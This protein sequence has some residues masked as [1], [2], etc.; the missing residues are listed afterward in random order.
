MKC[1]NLVNPNAIDNTN[2]H[3]SWKII[4]D[5]P[6]RQEA[7]EIQVASDSMLL[8]NGLPDLWNL[9][10]IDASTSVMVP[11]NG[12]A[13]SSR[14]LCWWRVRVWNGQGE[15]SAWSPV[16]RFGIGILDKADMKGSF[17]GL[18]SMKTPILRKK[19]TLIDKNTA[20]LHVN[21]LGYHEVYING[22]KVSEDVLSPAVSQ[23]NKRSL[24][25]T[26]DVSR[27]LRIG[28]NELV[29]WLGQGWYKQTAW[30][31]VDINILDGPVARAQ[32]DVR[33]NNSWNT[34]LVTDS[35]WKGRESG[36]EDTGTWNALRF[37]GEKVDAAKNP[38]DMYPAT[39][40]GLAWQ[41]AAVMN[42]P[43]HE[44]SPVMTEP[45]RIREKI[46]AKSVKK[47]N[48]NTW[49]VDMGKSLNGWFEL[50]L[51]KL[52][53]GQTIAID[54]TDDLT[55][56]GQWL[57]ME[58]GQ[59][60]K[61]IAMGKAGEIFCN[62]FNHHAFRYVKITNLPVKPAL[63]D[64]N[65]FLLHTDYRAASSFE[66]SDPDLNAIH[67]MIQYTMRC[68][69]FSGYMVDCPHLER[70]GYGGDGNS[71]T[72]SLQIMYDVAPL[73]ANWLQ[74]WSDAMRE[75]GSLPHVAPNP[76]AGGGGPYWCGFI[77]MASW[78]TYV[79]YGDSRLIEKY[80][81]AMKKWLGYVEKYTINGLLKRWPDLPY[82]DWYLGDWLAPSGVDSGN[83]SSIDLVNNCFIS[84]CFSKMEKIAAVLG[85]PVE[86]TVFAERRNSLNKL[87][88]TTYYN[89]DNKTYS[90]GSQLDMAYPML[91]GATPKEQYADVKK[92]LFENTENNHR[93][94]IAA[95][96]VGV[97]IVTRW[98]VENKAADFIYAM[99]KKRDYPGYLYMIDN[100]ATTTWESWN[101]DRSRIHN[102][103][104]GIGSWFY[105]AIGGIRPDEANPGYRHVFIEPQI[106]EG[107]SWAK[108]TKE[109]PYGTIAV[110]WEKQNG[111]IKFN[112][113][114]PV[115]CTAS[116]L[117]P[118]RA[119][120]LESGRHEIC[121]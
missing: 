65:A 33:Q 19:F 10:K 75:G 73:F 103:Y 78:Q 98:A 86:A 24:A 72:L 66:C 17:I 44:V 87:L 46:P 119:K 30:D 2:P 38:A 26:Y 32:L 100:G 14:S 91:A 93:G 48:S 31:R 118:E 74:A 113:A 58:G 117:L 70:A 7:F 82:R 89:P 25:V 99:L 111:Q 56:D 85:K 104:N 116:F 47:I 88:H 20:F 60:D 55:A 40:D 4:S 69:A 92:Q 102:C 1:E 67:D 71:S 77:I 109:T 57:E 43:D 16:A 15:V 27:Y 107:V 101:R 84:D 8:L 105:Q 115:G 3:F 62:K 108:V 61:Y 81:P 63:K 39:L 22:E 45:N 21:S 80:Y 12:A 64:M 96:L 51:P 34:L 37:G 41:P 95:G 59:A 35:T 94:H 110:N 90:T 83:Q 76:G 18:A 120:I 50:R 54:Y 23:F 5:K 53:E 121:Y 28:A 106:P 11:Y 112:I 9:G 79:N 97:P 49:L 29:I 6:M 114:I 36:Y 68:L 52:A 13:L 42:V